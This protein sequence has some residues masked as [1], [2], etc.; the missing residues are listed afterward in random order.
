MHEFFFWI[1][2][3]VVFLVVL[4]GIVMIHEGGHF[5]FA[6]KAGILCHE[7]SCGMGPLIVQKKKGETAYSLR[8]IPI[9]GYVAMAG[10]N[11]NEELLKVGTV[12][13]LN[14]DDNNEVKEII[15]TPKVKGSVTGKIIEYN[16][17][18]KEGEELH[19]TLEENG[20]EKYYIVSREAFYVMGVK[21]KTQIAP[22]DRCF[23]SKTKWQRFIT[24][25]AGPLMNFVLAFV[26][27]IIVGL[28][29]GVANT[30]SSVI[31]EITENYPAAS[32]GLKKGDKITALNG[33]PVESWDDFSEMMEK[34]PY[35]TE[36]VTISYERNGVEQAP[37]TIDTIITSYRLGI[38]NYNTTSTSKGLEVTVYNN[39]PMDKAKIPSGAVLKSYSTDNSEYKDI[40]TWKALLEDLEHEPKQIYFKYYE[41]KDSSEIKTSKAVTPWTSATLNSKAVGVDATWKAAIGVS[42]ATHFSFFGGLKNAVLL[43]ANSVTTV[44][45]TLGAL[46]GI[47]HTQITI[48]DL[49]GP[50]GILAAVKSYLG[51]D[52]ISFLSFVGLISANI[53]LVNLLPI[54]ALDGGRIVFIIIECITRKPV[55]KKVETWLNNIVFILILILFVYIT[56][57]DVINLF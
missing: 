35:G 46:F 47:G 50:V 3:I 21:E 43:F 39:W 56:I 25:F 26:I 15:C 34:L 22:Y 6:R 1:Y 55:N 33:K 53:G 31:G 14:L 42:C 16:L 9:G 27:F 38:S 2:A 40:T 32:V 10:E 17:Y 5:F 23:E 7:F 4:T 52:F 49:S 29:S 24:I 28:A 51:T 8:A 54:P 36:S 18:S 57:K 41:N 11:M 20:E 19:I 12:I 30:N 44:F 48:N 45:A 13:D 37:V